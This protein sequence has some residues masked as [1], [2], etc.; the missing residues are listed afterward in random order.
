MFFCFQSSS[1]CVYFDVFEGVI[2]IEI[3]ENKYHIENSMKLNRKTKNKNHNNNRKYL[4]E[5]IDSVQ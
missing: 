1:Y 3:V 4:R 2:S 5:I